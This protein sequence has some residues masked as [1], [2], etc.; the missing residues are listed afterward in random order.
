MPLVQGRETR[1]EKKT[2]KKVGDGVMVRISNRGIARRTRHL[3]HGVQMC[4]DQAKIAVDR[5][6]VKHDVSV[7]PFAEN[8]GTSGHAATSPQGG[9]MLVPHW[10]SEV[11]DRSAQACIT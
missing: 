8:N 6:S 9:T 2:G 5:E 11:S 1:F 7:T 10:G 3:Q 4:P